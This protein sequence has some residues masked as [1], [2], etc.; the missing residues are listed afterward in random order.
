MTLRLFGGVS[1]PML[2]FDQEI[3]DAGRDVANFLG[4]Y[5]GLLQFLGGDELVMQ[6]KQEV[7]FN[8][9][10]KP[11]MTIADALSE[12]YKFIAQQYSLPRQHI[13]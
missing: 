1:R 9:Q 5:S 12:H 2:D 8:M 10:N 13:I 3:I 6:M 7:I 4:A 11:G